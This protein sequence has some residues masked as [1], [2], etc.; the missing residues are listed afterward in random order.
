MCHKWQFRMTRAAIA[1]FES[2]NY[3]QIRNALIV[4]TKVCAGLEKICFRYNETKIYT[5]ML[6]IKIY[7]FISYFDE[8]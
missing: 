2:G 3:T 7:I 4:L 6:Y 5:F 8:L 1:C